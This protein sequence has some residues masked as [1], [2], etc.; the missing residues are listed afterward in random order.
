MSVCENSL[1]LWAPSLVAPLPKIL[2]ERAQRG[3]E[4]SQTGIGDYAGEHWSVLFAAPGIWPAARHADGRGGSGVAHCLRKHRQLDAG[5]LRR[6]SEGNCGAK[7][8]GCPKNAVD[9]TAAD[10]VRSAFD[11]RGRAWNF[12][13]AMGKRPA[14]SLYLDEKQSSACFSGFVAR[15]ARIELYRRGG[16]FNWATFRRFT[17]VSFYARSF[18]L[19]NERDSSG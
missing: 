13:R 4:F 6:A 3:R 9:S 19:R 15:L 12:V 14:G 16:G 18:G 8:A 11:D 2:E 7:G 1:P 5:S 17:S 10:R